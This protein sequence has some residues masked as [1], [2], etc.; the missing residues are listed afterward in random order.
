MFDLR[1]ETA[2]QLKYALQNL[3]T[4]F[5]LYNCFLDNT[6]EEKELLSDVICGIFKYGMNN[7]GLLNND[8]I[9]IENSEE[10][11]IVFSSLL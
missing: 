8:S 6:N 3:K 10:T 11:F 7:Y 2:R 5:N 1:L 9:D 4:D